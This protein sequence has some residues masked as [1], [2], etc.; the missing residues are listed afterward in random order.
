MANPFYSSRVQ[1]YMGDLL[2]TCYKVDLLPRLDL[3]PLVL[4]CS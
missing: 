1:P 3:V 2:S 4:C